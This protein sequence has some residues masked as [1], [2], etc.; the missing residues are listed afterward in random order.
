[1]AASKSVTKMAASKS[2][3]DL[4]LIPRTPQTLQVDGGK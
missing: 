2:V 3:T 1:M 4:C